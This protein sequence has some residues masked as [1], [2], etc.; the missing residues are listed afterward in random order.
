MNL[1]DLEYICALAE[2]Q[3]FGDAARAC[4]VSQPTL[5]GQIKKLEAYLGVQLFERSNKSVRITDVGGEVVILAHEARSAAA[6]IKDV[7]DAHRDPF[8]GHFQ[9]GLIPTIA[10]Y[11]I[12][13]FADRLA[14]DLPNFTMSY[15]ED[16]TA[17]LTSELLA[18]KL[19]AVL[20][21]SEAQSDSLNALPLYQ[22]PFWLVYRRNHVLAKRH[23]IKMQ[24]LTNENILLLSEGH[25]LRDQALSVCSHIPAQ[26]LNATSLETLINLVAIGQGVTL[27]PALAIGKGAMVNTAL[28]YTRIS[29]TNAVRHI[30]LVYRKHFP[31]PQLITRL[32][33]IICDGLP[34]SYVTQIV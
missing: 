20:L 29:D 4:H 24:D 8:A 7:C 2:H 12:P 19:D 3:H 10:P 34:A 14:T 13:L 11:L 30:Y 28:G 15:Y 5:S 22:E 21:A 17:R 32:A 16:I 9:L 23:E 25:C 26:T 33:K 1:R 18:G 6:R 27:V 31:R